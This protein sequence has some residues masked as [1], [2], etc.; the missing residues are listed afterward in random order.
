[1]KQR[2][3]SFFM[4]KGRIEALTDGVYAI[5]M[6]LLALN[7]TIPELIEEMNETRLWEILNG[8]MVKLDDYILSFMFLAIFWIIHNEQMH[9]VRKADRP[10]LWIQILCL[11]FVVLIP[12]ST[13]LVAFYGGLQVSDM[14]FELNILIIGLLYLA[15]WQYLSRNPQLSDGAPN[16]GAMDREKMKTFLIVVFSLV[17]MIVSFAFPG[18]ST[19]LY[20]LLPVLVALSTFRPVRKEGKKE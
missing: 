16:P 20:F 8:L 5:A 14:V 11:V 19:A 15:S 9:Y 4:S 3:P 10:F 6:T 1:M 18:W 13:S 7:L 2:D 12:T 17:A